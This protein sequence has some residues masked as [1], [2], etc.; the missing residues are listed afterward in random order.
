MPDKRS[1]TEPHPQMLLTPYED[2]SEKTQEKIR[3]KIKKNM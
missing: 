3:I 1:T 2:N